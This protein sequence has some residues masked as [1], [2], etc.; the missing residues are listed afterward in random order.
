MSGGPKKDWPGLG[1]DPAPGDQSAV[2]NLSATLRRV[3]QHLGAIHTTLGQISHHE[4]R[5]TGTAADKFAEQ[6][7]P[8]PGY[9]GDASDSLT[10]AYGAL[11]TWYKALTEHQPKATELERAAVLAAQHRTDASQAHTTATTNPDLKLAGQTFPDDASLA[12]AKAK[13]ETAKK[14]LDETAATLRGATEDLQHLRSQA[15]ALHT[16]HT[17]DARKTAAAIRKAADSKAPPEPGWLDKVGDWL[18]KHGADLLTVAASIAGVA[19]IFF[20]PLALAAVALSLAAAGAHA[21]K[22]G[23]SGLL[24]PSWDNL[25]NYLTLSGDILGA[26]P[27]LGAAGKGALVAK[28]GWRAGAATATKAGAAETVRAAKGIKF[29]DPANPVFTTLFE[30]P[31][32]FLGASRR[33]AQEISDLAQG[34]TTLALTAPTAVS[35]FDDNPG[36]DLN[37]AV[38]NTTGAAN[39]VGATGMAWS[40]GTKAKIAGGVAAFG[41]AFAT[42]WDWKAHQ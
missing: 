38:N 18:D 17:G 39:T 9:L 19:A 14:H 42:G 32:V 33:T 13:Y 40:G 26:V 15:A 6:F 28:A 10:A 23:T 11:D 8:L 27:L 41:N 24:P 7:G 5:W 36:S 20:P 34:A 37:N 3:A 21:V 25:G 1:F 31:A 16:T 12:A 29:L 4:G 30:K 35:L 22:Y 2:T